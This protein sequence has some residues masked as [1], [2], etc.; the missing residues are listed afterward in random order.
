MCVRFKANV[1]GFCQAPLNDA[2]GIL[3]PLVRGGV[4]GAVSPWMV[5]RTLGRLRP[6]LSRESERSRDI[7]LAQSH[8]V[9]FVSNSRHVIV[10]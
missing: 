4:G 1:P 5:S 7:T 9:A 2:T 10:G 8:R 6:L 3:L